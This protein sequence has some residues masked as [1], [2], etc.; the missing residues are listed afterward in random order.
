MNP[1]PEH[2]NSQ[3]KDIFSILLDYREIPIIIT[4]IILWY[5]IPS[6]FSSMMFLWIS[7]SVLAIL[8]SEI[9]EIIS[10]KIPQPYDSLILTISA[11]WVEILLL[12]MILKAWTWS[13]AWLIAKN[14]IISAVLVDITILFGLS[15]FI[16]WI[17]RKEQKHNEDSSESYTLILLVTCFVIA[18]PTL[19]KIEWNTNWLIN[20]WIYIS[21][22][23]LIFYFISLVFQTKT[24][25]HFFKD[26]WKKNILRPKINEDDNEPSIFDK[27]SIKINLLFLIILLLIVWF[28]A[29]EFWHKSME[30]IWEFGIP[31]W[32]A[33]IWIALISV[34]PELFTTIKAAKNN[35]IQKVVN[36][37]LG[38]SVVS[39]LITIPALTLLAKSYGLNFDL[40]LDYTQIITLF[41]A[42]LLA[43]RATNN[44]ET[45]YL[46]GISLLVLFWSYII[47]VLFR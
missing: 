17:M 22:L 28:I 26:L 3:K 8:V 32:I 20:S 35:E 34:F 5:T 24:H 33:W 19:F 42:V 46:K 29:E 1:L 38:A 37:S 10:E 16:W 40:S 47:M 39:I 15:L 13:H 4:S 2:P 11:V 6:V 21:I 41:F 9:A 30:I 23:L 45:D 7:I 12:F 44:W 25:V 14:W 43:W 36:I 27:F 18:I 31:I